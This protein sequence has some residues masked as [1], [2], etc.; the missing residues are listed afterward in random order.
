MPKRRIC[1]VLAGVLAAAC[2]SAGMGVPAT[3]GAAAGD[4]AAARAVEAVVADSFFG[5]IARSD[6]DGILRA[7]TPTYELNEDTLRLTGPRFV[8]LVRSFEGKA[9]IRYRLDGFNTRVVGRT[10]WTSYRNHGTLTPAGGTA[11]HPLE[12]SETAVL[13]QDASGRWRIDRMHSTPLNGGG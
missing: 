7:L 10:A 2:T 3:P 11:T 4:P 6:Y 5:A 9:A 12:W 13:V 8:A 1:F